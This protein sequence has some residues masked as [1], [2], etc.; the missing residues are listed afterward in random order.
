M[1]FF[2]KEVT[3]LKLRPEPISET[4]CVLHTY[5]NGIKKNLNLYLFQ[6]GFRLT[7]VLLGLKIS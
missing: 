2:C 5:T 1:T 7:Q 6:A 4:T 3:D